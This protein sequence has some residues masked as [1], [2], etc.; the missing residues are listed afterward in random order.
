MMDLN[1]RLATRYYLVSV[2]WG[3]GTIVED[4]AKRNTLNELGGWAKGG[5][6]RGRVAIRKPNRWMDE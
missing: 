3:E 4:F 6:R 2:N 1:F 5:I